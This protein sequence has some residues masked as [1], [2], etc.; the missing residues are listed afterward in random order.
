MAGQPTNYERPYCIRLFCSKAGGPW[1]LN[2]R[3]H[4]GVFNFASVFRL[5]VNRTPGISGVLRGLKP[6]NVP[7]VSA[8]QKLPLFMKIP[9][10]AG[11]GM[12]HTP[13]LECSRIPPVYRKTGVVSL[14]IRRWSDGSW[15]NRKGGRTDRWT[16]PVRFFSSFPCFCIVLRISAAGFPAPPDPA[17]D[18][19]DQ[20]ADSFFSRRS[21]QFIL[22]HAFY[23]ARSGL[24]MHG[25]LRIW[26]F[27]FPYVTSFLYDAIQRKISRAYRQIK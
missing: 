9:L 3:P 22:S 10:F 11:C 21:Q 5:S 6:V 14:L 12:P 23:C 16:T 25:V 24:S 26:D 19:K 2:R 1:S 27:A 13:L 4:T 7:Q 20:A 15:L 17:A 18:I 8:F